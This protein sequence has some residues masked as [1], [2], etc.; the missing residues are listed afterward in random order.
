M[1]ICRWGVLSQ[2]PQPESWWSSAVVQ[3]QGWVG[4]LKAPQFAQH[5]GSQAWQ[6]LS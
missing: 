6:V 3:G 5:R 2:D 1:G 4:S